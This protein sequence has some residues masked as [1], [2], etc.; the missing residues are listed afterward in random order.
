MTAI[1]DLAKELFVDSKVSVYLYGSR[2]RGEAVNS[3]DWDLL[4][5]A[6]DGV[7]IEN[8]F[9]KY[10]YP[11]TEIGWKLGEQITPVLYTKSEWAAEEHTAFYMNVQND[12]ILL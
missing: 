4:I 10:A 1:R 6:E 9:E 5:V 3:S 7:D 8:A 12:A 11:F 2:A